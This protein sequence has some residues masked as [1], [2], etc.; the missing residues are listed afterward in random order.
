MDYRARALRG[1]FKAVR[2]L[3]RDTLVTCIFLQQR[4]RGFREDRSNARD[5]G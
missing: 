3:P 2:Y 4:T 1:S 5:G